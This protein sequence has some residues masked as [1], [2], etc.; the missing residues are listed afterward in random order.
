MAYYKPKAYTKGWRNHYGEMNINVARKFDGFGS[1][2]LMVNPSDKL[3]SFESLCIRINGPQH[4]PQGSYVEVVIK[5][6]W[7]SDWIANG[8]ECISQLGLNGNETAYIKVYNEQNLL[9][10]Q[11]G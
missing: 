2:T 6:K 3:S 9:C 11:Q 1:K 4:I 8:Y 7:L 5:G 10:I